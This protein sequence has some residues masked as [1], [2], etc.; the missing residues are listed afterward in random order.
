MRRFIAILISNLGFCLSAM[1]QS[2]YGTIYLT[3]QP[4]PN[5]TTTVCAHADE[6][7]RGV[8]GIDLQFHLPQGFTVVGEG[9]AAFREGNFADG[10]LVA[11]NTPD[12]RSVHVAIVSYRGW[13]G[14]Y[15]IGCIDVTVPVLTGGE[16]M[17]EAN[18]NDENGTIPVNLRLVTIL[19]GGDLNGDLTV[20]LAD[21]RQA[22]RAILGLD[23]TPHSPLPDL[24]GDGEVDI[25][26]AQRLLKLLLQSA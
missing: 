4:G 16:V 18:P 6:K 14:P 11:V 1:S 17:L 12:P 7:V 5:G 2:P 22:L 25:G 8:A 10:A 13:D 21:V 24:D 26:D 9:R 20:N 19:P 3:A 15:D 23:S